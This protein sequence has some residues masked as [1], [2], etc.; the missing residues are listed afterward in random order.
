MNYLSES[1]PTYSKWLQQELERQC[2]E[3]YISGE[4]EL[5]K[6]NEEG[7]RISIRVEIPHKNSSGNVSFMTG[8]MV[9]PDGHIRLTTPY[10]GK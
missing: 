6:L 5:G 8:W 4:Y 2:L 10:G 3:K 7:Q 9:H 1:T